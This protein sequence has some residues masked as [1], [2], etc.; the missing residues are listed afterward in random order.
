MGLSPDKSSDGFLHDK[1]TK[2]QRRQQAF[3]LTVVILVIAAVSAA[4]AV[5]RQTEEQHVEG[6]TSL[7]LDEPA[8]VMT[9]SPVPEQPAT[10][11]LPAPAAVAA[12]S[13]APGP[14]ASPSVLTGKVIVI[15]PGH[16]ASPDPGMEP[17]GPG[18]SQM[19]VKDPGGTSGV[20]S[21]VR[22]ADVNLAISTYLKSELEAEGARVVMT[23]EGDT[24]SGGNRERAQ[25]ANNAG[26]A[27][28]IRIHCD[29]ATNPG[30]HGASTLYPASVTGWTDDIYEPSRRAAAAV[31]SSLAV[32]LGAAD[33]GTVERSDM[34]GF[35]W[36]DVPVIL[37]E[38]GFMTNPDEDRKLNT[39]GYQRQAARAMMLGIRD[40]LASS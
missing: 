34:T 9:G 21:G 29:G 12:P 38:V 35:N 15:D 40:F 19:K 2:R 6:S 14:A 27:L 23:R 33:N 30:T 28:L 20:S 26:A 11:P 13:A 5:Y 10:V 1:R 8:M 4:A 18:S 17:I 36:S 22:E 39:P 3:F 24:F 31:Q 25:M 32:N 16:A 7:A 37:V